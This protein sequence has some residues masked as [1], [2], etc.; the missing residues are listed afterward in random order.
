MRALAEAARMLAEAVERSDA[1]R[2]VAAV[3]EAHARMH[4]LGR[5]ADVPI[6]TPPFAAAAELAAELDGAAKPSGA[7]GGD[8]GVAVFA[9]AEAAAAFRARAPGLGLSIVPLHID[10]Q[11]LCPIQAAEPVQ[12]IDRNHVARKA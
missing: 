11:G 12:K 2:A 5:A 7:G 8:V 10:P 3:R 4:E 9:G 1:P 6:V